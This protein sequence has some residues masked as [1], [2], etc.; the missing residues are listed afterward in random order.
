VHVLLVNYSLR[1]I[2]GA[3]IY[4]RTNIDALVQLGYRVTAVTADAE[5]PPVPDG[6]RWL[7]CLD[8][9]STSLSRFR[10]SVRGVG[11][12][13]AVLEADPPDVAL[14]H[15]FDALPGIR[16][17]E[18]TVPTIRFVH[19][20]WPYCP[21][22]SRWLPR[23]NR[24]C[25]SEVGL[26]CLAVDREE[27]CLVTLSGEPFGLRN[28]IRRLLDMGFQRSFFKGATLIAANS[29]YTDRE[30]RR[31]A[32]PTPRI[33]VLPPPVP[34]SALPDQDPVP[35]RLLVAG[36][37]TRAK[38]VQDAIR[39]IASVPRA[40]LHVAGD[41]PYR[42]SLEALVDELG[43]RSRVSFLGWLDKAGIESEMRA[44]QVIVFPSCWPETFGQVGVQAAFCGR[45][46]VAYDA[47]GVRDW[48]TAESGVLVPVGS[49]DGLADAVA[50]LIADPAR[51]RTLGERG[52]AF[53]VRF[54][55]PAFTARIEHA[56]DAAIAAWNLS[57]R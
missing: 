21:A 35:G 30:V 49:V 29:S 13:R 10:D 5:R 22:G 44:A 54:G 19:T 47:G 6:V 15:L 27:G 28:S 16:L 12:V 38:G 4:A 50:S 37:L 34:R 17:L 32:G 55:I 26:R 41:G 7:G 57:R 23:A 25:E 52:H 33:I 3:E 36:R 20:A 9:F 24:P 46:V 8:F 1:P 31:F 39:A 45:P 56:I 40:H 51:C 11:T 2:G 53:A 43:L 14:L 18:R 42:A 48:L